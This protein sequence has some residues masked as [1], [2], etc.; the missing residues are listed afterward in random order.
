M[1][2]NL[3]KLREQSKK[4]QRQV[5]NELSVNYGTYFGWENGDTEPSIENLTKLAN[6]F[7]VSIDYLV[8][9]EFGNDIG[10]ITKEQQKT[11]KKFLTLEELN[12]IK[13]S[14]YIDSLFDNEKNN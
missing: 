7:N 12:Q 3:R 4:S 6:Y 11:F 8:G 1:V 9:R 2:N 13:A 5:S 14:G 10:F